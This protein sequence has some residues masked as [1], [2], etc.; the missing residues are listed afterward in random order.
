MS[1]FTNTVAAGESS[2]GAPLHYRIDPTARLVRIAYL[3]EPTFEQWAAAMEAIFA[4]PAYQI[5]FNF[6][7]D[8]SAVTQ[9]QTTLYIQR[10]SGFVIDHEAHLRGSRLA[11]VA[12]DLATYGMGRMSGQ[13]I[14]K[15]PVAQ[16]VFTDVRLALAWLAGTAQELE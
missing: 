2:S 9:P 7:F 6:L 13:L 5:G 12:T 3:A 16:A 15:A 14:A 11:L 8:R 1:R 4:D 10:V